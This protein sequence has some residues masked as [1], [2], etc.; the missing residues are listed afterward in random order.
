MAIEIKPGTR[1]LAPH[2]QNQSKNASPA[3]SDKFDAVLS[4][5]LQNVEGSEVAAPAATIENADRVVF[6]NVIQEMRKRIDTSSEQTIDTE[7][8]VRI[9]QAIEDGTYVINP[10][11]I[12]AKILSFAY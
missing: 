9:R 6:T 4:E 7:K 5:K 8:V 3:N 12:A 2:Y 1:S 10:E 11:R